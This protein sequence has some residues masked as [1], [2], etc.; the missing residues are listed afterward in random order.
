M[1]RE[2]ALLSLTAVGKT[3]FVVLPPPTTPGSSGRRGGNWVATWSQLDARIPFAQLRQLLGFGIRVFIPLALGR[4]LEYA[5][6]CSC[7]HMCTYTCVH[8]YIHIKSHGYM[9]TYRH[10]YLCTLR[11]CV[12]HPEGFVSLWLHRKTGHRM[13]RGD[14]SAFGSLSV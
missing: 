11:V 2:F 5:H 8:K 6:L 1:S 3:Y 7:I 13:V 10:T 9:H 4:E 12:V 14:F